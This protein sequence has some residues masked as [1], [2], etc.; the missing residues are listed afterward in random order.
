MESGR[1]GGP[2]L[3]IVEILAN[4]LPTGL[5]HRLPA[6][7]PSLKRWQFAQSPQYE[8]GIFIVLSIVGIFFIT[9]FLVAFFTNGLTTG[10]TNDG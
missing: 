10:S 2:I 6:G 9:I 3:Y 7:G 4:A 5:A 1:I 8:C